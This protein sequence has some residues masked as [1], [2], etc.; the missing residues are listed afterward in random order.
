M[1]ELS[2][3]HF[4]FSLGAL[5]LLTSSWSLLAQA[6]ATAMLSGIIT[7]SSGAV[8]VGATISARNLATNQYTEVQSNSGGAYSVMNLAPGEY[9]VSISSDA[10]STKIIRVT[11]AANGRQMQDQT[12]SPSSADAPSLGD[13]GFG[14]NH[15]RGSAQDEARVDRR[16]HML[17]SIN[18]SA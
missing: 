2:R 9:E 8:V 7:N 17:M 3:F 18:G 15:A 13:L 5:V 1:T 10:L 4:R 11:L 16:T 14:P 6:P 12:L